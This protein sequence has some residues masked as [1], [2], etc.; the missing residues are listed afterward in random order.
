MLKIIANPSKIITVDTFGRNVKRGAE[1]SDIGLLKGYSILIEDEFIKDIIPTRSISSIDADEII[2]ADGKI[3][4]PGFVD[5]HTHSVFA[6][7]RSNE[8]SS[9]LKGI[10]YEE[11]AASGGGINNTVD[12]IRKTNV[13]ELIKITIPRHRLFY[14]AGN[15]NS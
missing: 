4:L 2:D 10:T 13:E 5:C 8:F 12:A 14:F 9:R 6:G 11:I 15:N 7:S 3:V 1:L